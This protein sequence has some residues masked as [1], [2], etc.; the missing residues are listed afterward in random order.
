M[1]CARPA[2]R[3]GERRQG[4]RA[5]AAV[6]RTIIIRSLVSVLTYCIY[7][8]TTIPTPCCVHGVFH[9]FWAERGG[10]MVLIGNTAKTRNVLSVILKTVMIHLGFHRLPLRFLQPR[11]PSV[12]CG[13]TDTYKSAGTRTWFGE[14]RPRY[15]M[16]RTTPNWAQSLSNDKRREF[17]GSTRTSM[18][19][20]WA[21]VC[22]AERLSLVL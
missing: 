16:E 7:V 17:E 18:G 21:G 11:A 8:Q 14:P 13:L 2:Q 1:A 4:G 22:C 20:G 3:E 12:L 10:I 6:P 15:S 5:S 9:G 19:E